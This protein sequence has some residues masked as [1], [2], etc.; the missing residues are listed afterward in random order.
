MIFK[1]KFGASNEAFT[2]AWS[3]ALRLSPIV[4]VAARTEP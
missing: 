3:A 2:A 4:P 1:R